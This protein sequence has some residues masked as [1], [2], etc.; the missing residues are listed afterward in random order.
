[1]L[2]SYTA[3]PRESMKKFIKE[4][5]EFHEEALKADS[6]TRE[7]AQLCIEKGIYA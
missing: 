1:M 7:R 4:H 3:D 5:P 6:R 2:L